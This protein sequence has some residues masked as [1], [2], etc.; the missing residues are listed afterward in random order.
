MF[1]THPTY[2]VIRNGAEKADGRKKSLKK[3]PQK[4]QETQDYELRSLLSNT[5][6]HEN[7]RRP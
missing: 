7:F 6:N 1:F 5:I 3:S 4:P 2:D